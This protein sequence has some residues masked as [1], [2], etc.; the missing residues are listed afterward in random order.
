MRSRYA[1]AAAT[2]ATG[3]TRFGITIARA[4]CRVVNGR[5]AASIT[6]SRKWTCQSSGRRK[7]I[8]LLFSGMCAP[9]TPFPW[10]AL[11]RRIV[12]SDFSS[13]LAQRVLILVPQG[14]SQNLYHLPREGDRI[15]T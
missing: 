9:Q 2:S 3:G 1:Y 13:T 4:N 10:H 8:G 5:T 15:Q 6:P 7:V 14:Y 12:T 11:V